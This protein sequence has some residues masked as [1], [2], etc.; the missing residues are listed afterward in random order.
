VGV[1]AGEGPRPGGGR[2]A[3]SVVI[4]RRVWRCIRPGAGPSWLVAQFPAPL[5]GCA[6]VKVNPQFRT[7]MPVSSV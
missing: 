1:P 6:P 5:V 3:G 2:G 7:L 4:G